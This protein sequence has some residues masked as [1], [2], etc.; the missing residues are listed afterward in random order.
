[1]KYL[2]MPLLLLALGTHTLSAQSA[3]SLSGVIDIHAHADPDDTSKRP[4]S[5]DVIDLAKLAK[6]R[7]MR[8][9]VLKNHYESTASLAYAVRKA[10]P[11]IEV[12]GMIVLN[13]QVGGIN[14]AAVDYM[15]KAKGGYGRIVS[16]P[17]EDAENQVKYE[18]SNR[19]FV[20]IA[21]NGQL[22]P[23]VKEVLSMIA[24]NNL[25]L[26]T[27]HS[28]AAENLLLVREAH[29]AGIRKII[30]THPMGRAVAMTIPQM[31]EAAKFGAFLEIVT[32]QRQ[33]SNVPPIT[34]QEHVQALRGVGIEHFILSTDTGQ[35]G[36]PLHPDA[37]ITL[38]TTLREQGF[39]QTEID[40]MSKQ[41][42]AALLGLQ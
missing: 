30:V 15:I 4:R 18:K 13:R 41:N 29:G 35:G 23:E 39:S 5:I 3:Q 26:A 1:M 32:Y 9:F 40:R 10:V 11:G 27:G 34:T 28:S 21:R 42:P 7:G 37:F 25:A 14:P 8:G 2:A 36:N 6:D 38:F 16:M 31:Q 17:T 12:W 33:T 19:P 24:R 20:S 22:L